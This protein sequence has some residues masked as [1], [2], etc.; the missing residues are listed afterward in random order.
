VEYFYHAAA[1]RS[2]LGDEPAP[3]EVEF[4]YPGPMPRSRE[5]AILMLADAAESSVRATPEPT[6]GRIETQVHQ[7]VTKR[8]TDGQLDDCDLTLREVHGIERSLVKS[9]TSIHHGRVQYPSQKAPRP[10]DNGRGAVT[11]DT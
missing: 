5:A 3:D 6:P 8:L 9:L 7:I 1:E 2:K 4:R 11:A 10:D